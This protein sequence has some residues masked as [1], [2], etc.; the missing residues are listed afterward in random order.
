MV[1][2]LV[3]SRYSVSNDALA[4]KERMQQSIEVIENARDLRLSELNLIG[5]VARRTKENRCFIRLKS[6]QFSWQRG[7]K[8]GQCLPFHSLE[9]YTSISNKQNQIYYNII[10]NININNDDN[11]D[12]NI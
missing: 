2:L 7:V 11:N 10:V 1:D 9:R 12:N 8:I 3:G 4:Q 6:V 5:R